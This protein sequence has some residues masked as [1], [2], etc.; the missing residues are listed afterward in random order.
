MQLKYTEPT[1]DFSNGLVVLKA[2]HED[3]LA[4]G[5]KLLALVD[6]IKQQGMNESFAN[7]C[8]AMYWHY[9]HANQLHH[10]DE[11]QA[12]FPLLLGKSPLI[13][14]MMEK[15]I[16]DHEEI[17]K[18]WALL[19]KQLK[20][21][22]NITDFENLEILAQDFEKLEREHINREDEDF[23]PKIKIILS[24]EGMLQIGQK[25]QELRHL[26]LKKNQ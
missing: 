6:E 8:L 10:Q 20:Q 16:T 13:E 1:N 21:P 18:A 3:F 14:A 7:Q 9:H 15:L 25:M 24:A 11:E 19:A 23:S 2:Y 12:L 4:R 5:V 26:G 17:E 22:D